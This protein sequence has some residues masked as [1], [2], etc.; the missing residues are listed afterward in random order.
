M[1]GPL[2]TTGPF[3]YIDFLNTFSTY[4]SQFQEKNTTTTMKA[5]FSL[6]NL[7]LCLDPADIQKAMHRDNPGRAAGPIPGCIIRECANQVVH[8]RTDI[9]NT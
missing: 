6:D 5:P 1:A 9:S 4:F 7:V 2:Q 8:I 3:H